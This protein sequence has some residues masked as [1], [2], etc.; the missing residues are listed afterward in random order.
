MGNNDHGAM[1]EYFRRMSNMGMEARGCATHNI[2]TAEA[3]SEELLR[4]VVVS[5][6]AL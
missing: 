3:D 4:S 2:H 1:M 6:A 5:L